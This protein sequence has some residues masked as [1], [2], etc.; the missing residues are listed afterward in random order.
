MHLH[1]LC[2]QCFTV[3]LCSASQWPFAVLHSGPLL[4][5]QRNVPASLLAE[6]M[7]PLVFP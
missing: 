3:A 6:R 5:C 7:C 2:L 1:W 4:L